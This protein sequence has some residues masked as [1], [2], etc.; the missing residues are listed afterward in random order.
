MLQALDALDPVK[1]QLQR[2]LPVTINSHGKNNATPSVNI[3]R[4]RKND[5]TQNS[6]HEEPIKHSDLGP[7][8]NAHETHRQPEP[9]REA[10]RACKQSSQVDG[11]LRRADCKDLAQR[12]LFGEDLED[13]ALPQRET[14]IGQSD[15]A[16]PSNLLPP[17]NM[18]TKHRT[19]HRG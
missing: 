2:D 4:K 16:G 1:P 13:A 9:T 14:G 6:G 18:Q 8:G 12:L 7:N 17:G 15:S 10:K 3:A 5:L 11:S 19:V